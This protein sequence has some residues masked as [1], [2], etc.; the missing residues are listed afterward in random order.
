[1]GVVP[2]KITTD[3]SL[4]AARSARGQRAGRAGEPLSGGRGPA[5]SK[6][7]SETG[8]RGVSR[9]YCHRRPVRKGREAVTAL[10]AQELMGRGES[11]FRY[12]AV[13]RSYGARAAG[14]RAFYTNLI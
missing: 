1:M 4:H 8:A 6:S 13:S 10:P 3:N 11:P 5:L 12:A 9:G 14:T 7:G 2:P